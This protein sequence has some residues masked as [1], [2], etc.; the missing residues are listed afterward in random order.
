MANR[1]ERQVRLDQIRMAGQQNLESR[2]EEL[3]RDVGVLSVGSC[4]VNGNGER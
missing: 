4:F 2:I 3:E 1:Q